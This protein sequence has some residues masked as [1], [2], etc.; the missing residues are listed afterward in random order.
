MF[1]IMK[2]HFVLAIHPESL[3]KVFGIIRKTNDLIKLVVLEY[4][5]YHKKMQISSYEIQ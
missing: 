5:N 2:K 3:E 4:I 1:A